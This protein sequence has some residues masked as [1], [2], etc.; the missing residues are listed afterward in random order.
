MADLSTLAPIIAG[1]AL[2]LFAVGVA[3]W[4][5]YTTPVIERVSQQRPEE[6]ARGPFEDANSTTAYYLSEE[7][8]SQ[9]LGKGTRDVLTAPS[10]SSLTEELGGTVIARRRAQ[11]SADT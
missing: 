7:L 3:L 5:N 6:E 1:G 8:L 11:Q 4:F 9:I 2:L 10:P